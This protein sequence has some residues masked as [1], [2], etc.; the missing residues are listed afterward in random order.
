MILLGGCA[1][2]DAT[3]PAASTTAATVSPDAAAM[4]TPESLVGAVSEAFGRDDW[5]QVRRLLASTLT[6]Q[7]AEAGMT[8]DAWLSLWDGEF[9]RARDF[10]IEGASAAPESTE[11]TVKVAFSIAGARRESAIR[12]VKEEGGWRWAER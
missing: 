5:D 3:G 9:E 11:A 1:S 2:T 12:V 7:V 6:A 4:A 8:V 10:R